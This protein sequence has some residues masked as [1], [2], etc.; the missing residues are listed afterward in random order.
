MSDTANNAEPNVRSGRYFIVESKIRC[1]QCDVVSTVFAFAVPAGYE[2]RHV[3]DDTPDDESGTWESQEVAAV[4]SYVEYLPDAVV[5]RV[6]AMTPHYRLD[7]R[8]ETGGSFWMNHCEGCGAQVD[9]EELHE[10]EGPFGLEP[11]EGPEAIR[12]HEVR[13][14]FEAWAGGESHDV[15]PLNS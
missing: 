3:G 4:L 5:N 11:F 12:P 1:P 2:S 6:R 9:E 7:R 15:K 14:P 8:G 10:F 13:E